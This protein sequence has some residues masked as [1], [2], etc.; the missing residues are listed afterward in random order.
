MF[1]KEILNL[2]G[3]RKIMVL[4]VGNSFLQAIFIIIQALSLAK[5]I[6][7]LWNGGAL[8]QIIPTM[9]CFAIAFMLHYLC[10]ALRDKLLI[11]YSRQQAQDLREQLLK[12]IFKLGPVLISKQGT[13]N[14]VT[15]SMEGIDQVEQ[16]LTLILSK[17]IDMIVIPV[18]VLITVF[19]LDRV[20][21]LILLLAFP[22]IILFMVILGQAAKSKADQQ[23]ATFQQLTNHFAD[24][25]RGL[26]TLKQLGIARQHEKSIFKTSERFRKATMKTLVVAMTSS[27]ALDF[28]TTLSI[29]IVAVC[30]GFKLINGHILLFPALA[31]LILSPEYFLPIQN[32]GNDYHATLNGKNSFKAIQQIL[33]MPLKHENQINL[34]LWDEQSDLKIENLRIGYENQT[35]LNDV[36]FEISG[37]KKIGIVGLSGSGKSTLINTLGGF[38][39]PKSGKIKINEVELSS[40]DQKEWQKQI[41]YIPQKPYIFQNTLKNNI[42]FYTPNATDSEVMEAIKIVGLDKLV[43]QLPD[44]IETQIGEGARALSG[45]Q[46]Q[47]IALARAFLDKNRH[48]MLF[49]EPTA[50]LDIE[51]ELD[52]KEKMLPI[53][54]KHLVFFATHRLHWLKQMDKILVLKDG[55]VAEQGTLEELMSKNGELVRLIKEM[56]SSNEE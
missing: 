23:F 27:F 2:P 25:I 45:G 38:I 21:G 16:Y 4:L 49:D 55:C 34:P 52:L 32:F 10:D 28:F 43:K 46:A 29:A 33:K 9:I 53:M 6:T 7:V 30:L 15:M 22:L 40:F 36:D 1:D 24:S 44:G 42:K 39:K 31:A 17:A 20:S 47:R 8:G 54:N 18:M 11:T 35:I 37:M 5:T 13:G 12:K 56:Q 26:R 48:I 41:I 51:T 3:I 50:H 14:I 19:I